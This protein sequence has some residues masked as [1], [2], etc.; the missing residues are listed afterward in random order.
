MPLIEVRYLEGMNIEEKMEV[1][2]KRLISQS[3][4]I[5]TIKSCIGGQLTSEIT[6][7]EGGFRSIT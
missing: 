2:V 3:K 6:N 1:I 4:T 5:A 7:V